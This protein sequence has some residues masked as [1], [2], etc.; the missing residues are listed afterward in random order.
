[1]GVGG[2]C[3]MNYIELQLRHLITFQMEIV[4]PRDGMNEHIIVLKAPESIDF[5]PDNFILD[6]S[7][8]RGGKF[9]TPKTTH[10]HFR[11][12]GGIKR[13]KFLGYTKKYR[14]IRRTQPNKY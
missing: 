2:G 4:P 3:Q 11:L 13:M 14:N 8:I 1:M 5:E 6:K 9:A 12:V 7:E 10:L